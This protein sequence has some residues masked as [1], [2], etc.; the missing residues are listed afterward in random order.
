MKSLDFELEKRSILP[1]LL[2]AYDEA[3]IGSEIVKSTRPEDLNQKSC[4]TD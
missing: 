2:P 1:V 4:E 3:E